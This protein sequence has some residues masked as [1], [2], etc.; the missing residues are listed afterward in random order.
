MRLSSPTSVASSLRFAGS[1][2]PSLDECTRAGR[3]VASEAEVV[4]GVEPWLGQVSV[5][6]S[7]VPLLAQ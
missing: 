5:Q 6:L 3:L 4:V 1:T 2:T 7:V